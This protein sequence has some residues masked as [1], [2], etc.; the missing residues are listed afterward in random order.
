M[1]KDLVDFIRGLYKEDSNFLPLHEPRFVGNEKKYVVDAID[2]TFVSS[3]GA[4]VNKFEEMMNKVHNEMNIKMDCV[5]PEEH[6]AAA[7][8]ND[9]TCQR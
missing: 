2:S 4:Y 3:V 8:Q 5:A 1:Y 6:Q 9:G 7:A